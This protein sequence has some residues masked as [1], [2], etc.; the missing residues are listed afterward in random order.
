MCEDCT[1]YTQVLGFQNTQYQANS[2]THES[3][4]QAQDSEQSKGMPN[5]KHRRYVVEPLTHKR[6]I[7]II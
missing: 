5:S 3:S 1:F 2:P 4:N 6:K 7:E